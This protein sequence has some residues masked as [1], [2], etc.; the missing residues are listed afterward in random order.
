MDVRAERLSG[1]ATRMVVPIVPV[2]SAP[3]P[4]RDLNPVFEIAGQ[5]GAMLTQPMAAFPRAKLGIAAASVAE[6]HDLITRAL[7]I[8]LLG[9]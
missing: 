7:D 5:H 3:A 4:I 6:H 1:L 9:L 2:G 8:L